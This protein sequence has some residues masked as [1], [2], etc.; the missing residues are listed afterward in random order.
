MGSRTRQTQSQKGKLLI[1][2]AKFE[3]EQDRRKYEE[4]KAEL[5]V[6][7]FYLL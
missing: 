4:G 5:S 3:N 2:L 6:P 1:Q 7:N